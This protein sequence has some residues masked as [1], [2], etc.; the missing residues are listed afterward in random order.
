MKEEIQKLKKGDTFKVLLPQS[1]YIKLPIERGEYEIIQT[2]WHDR[3][4]NLEFFF[5]KIQTQRTDNKIYSCRSDVLV[6]I[7][8]LELLETRLL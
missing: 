4:T 1:E 8:K 5:Y 3:G 7:E 2:E 6:E